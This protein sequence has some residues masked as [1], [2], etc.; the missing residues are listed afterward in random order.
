VTIE[1]KTRAAG[2]GPAPTAGIDLSLTSEDEAFQAE[3]RDW[4]AENSPK[5]PLKP[6]DTAEG[7]AEHRAWERRLYEGGWGTVAWPKEYGGR[8]ATLIQSLL[9]EEEYSLAGAPIRVNQNGLAMLGPTL[10]SHGTAA[11][12][13]RF[14]RRLASGDDIWAQA[15]SEPNSGSDLASLRSRADLH[16]DNFVLHGQ[17]TW[18]SRGGQADWMF[19]LVRTDPET[20]N[21]HGLTFLL[22]PLRLD[23]I[24][25]RPLE[26]IDGRSGFAEIFMDGARVPIENVVGDV[27]QGWRVAMATLGFERSAF[28]RPPGRFSRVASQL[29]DLAKTQGAGPS[30]RDRL[31]GAWAATNAYRLLNYWS[32]S[33]GD[34]GQASPVQA[35]VNKIIWSEMDISLHELALALIGARG[36][37]W[38]GAPDAVN[39]GLWMRDFMFSL[40]GTIYAGSSEIQRNIIAERGLGLPRE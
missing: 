21:H 27:G 24:T 36:E 39:D 4:L 10:L 14:L 28:L 12:K 17:K 33:Q 40:A 15:W 19:T 35:N 8:Q 16:D 26:Q 5:E 13:D 3:A 38:A 30:M 20:N 6:F 34:H 18:V 9:F 2:G 23:G 37:L 25:V 11:Q 29:L 7:L 1:H 31:A 32:A 22:V